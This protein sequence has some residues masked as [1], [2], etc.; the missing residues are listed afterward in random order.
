MTT[1]GELVDTIVSSLHS[2]SGVHE[3]S[4]Y[5]TAAVD[6]DDLTLSVASSDAI[7]RGLAEIE[8]E[9]VYVETSDSGGL[10]VAPYGRGYRGTTAAAHALN[11]Q[12]LFDPIFP[13]DSICKTINQCVAGLFPQLYQVKATDITFTPQPIGYELPEDVAEILE[14]KFQSP[15]DPYNY[16]QPVRRYDFDTNSPETTGNALNLFHNLPSGST[17]RVVYMAPFGSFTDA[18]DTFA[19]VGLSESYA[20]LILYGVTARLVRFLD[21]ARLQVTAV[22]NLSR[23]QVVQVG[24]A[25]KVANQLYAMYQ[26]RLDEE[27]K[28]L[29]NLNPARLH[30]TR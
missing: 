19:D 3:Q 24:D 25:G 16:W 29:L 30:Y 23:A 8:D 18:A 12:V 17:V 22:E 5:L 4:T 7:M 2:F 9:L 28:R 6:A 1:Y 27:R 20:D 21:P 10:S 26:Q 15:D 13:R 14:V 11:T